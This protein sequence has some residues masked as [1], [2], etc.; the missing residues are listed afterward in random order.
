MKY[1]VVENLE[2][3]EEEIFLFPD[4]VHHDCM[5]EVLRCI[6]NQS[7]GNWER[8]DRHPVSAGFVEHGQCVGESISLNLRSRQQDTA[9]LRDYVTLTQ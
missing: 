5:A 6:R 9:I 8:V 3:N 4:S 7:F 2:T 1:I